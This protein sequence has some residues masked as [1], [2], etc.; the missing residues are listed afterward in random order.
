MATLR[1]FINANQQVQIEPED[2][3]SEEIWANVL[4]F[5]LLGSRI[6]SGISFI[7]IDESMYC[8]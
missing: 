2:K 6:N 5:W 8:R 3:I 4:D 1:L 7:E